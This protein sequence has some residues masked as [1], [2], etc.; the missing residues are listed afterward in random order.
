[1]R[2]PYKQ[3]SMIYAQSNRRGPDNRHVRQKLQSS[4]YTYVQKTKTNLIKVKE[5]TMS[6]QIELINKEVNVKK[7]KDLIG[8]C[9]IESIINK[10]KNLLQASLEDMTWLEKEFEKLKID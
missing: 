4:Y 5:S 8:N 2:H 3:E 10:I 9:K 1:M 7:K 6:Q